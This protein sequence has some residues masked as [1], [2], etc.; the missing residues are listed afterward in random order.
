[1]KINIMCD[2][3]TFLHRVNKVFI[4]RLHVVVVVVVVRLNEASLTFHYFPVFVLS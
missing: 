3:Y 4:L 2:F 1:M